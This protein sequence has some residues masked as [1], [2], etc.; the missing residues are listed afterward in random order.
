M[1][2][3]R[4]SSC[5]IIGLSLLGLLLC[6]LVAVGAFFLQG[7]PLPVPSHQ[8]LFEGVT[9]HRKVHWLPH[10]MVAH[11]VEVDLNA[12]GLEFLVTPPDDPESDLP[13]RART[14]SQF[15]S[16]YNLQLAINGTFFTPWYSNSVDDYY[17]RVG[18]P[19]RPNGFNASRGFKYSY[20][21]GATLYIDASNHASF[22]EP[23]GEV[24]NAIG[25][26]Q[27]LVA[28][29]RVVDG[30]PADLPAPRTA[31]G[32]TADG[33]RLILVVVDGRQLLYSQGAT[34]Q[35][36]AELMLS[37]GAYTAMNLDGGGSSTLVIAGPDG[38]R[39]LNSPIDNNIPGRERPVANHLGL[40]ANQR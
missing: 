23:A 29:G 12:P 18:D 24:Y 11:V 3:R 6:C 5:W 37:Y 32:L 31:V 34:L 16:E 40:Y 35:E 38:P 13:L 30:L 4:R 39:V 20:G 17:P 22:L 9:Y 10:P 26:G 25:G 7:R 14:T 15:L 33:T 8:T 19:V 1:T 36:L 27:L 21:S 28:D 2:R